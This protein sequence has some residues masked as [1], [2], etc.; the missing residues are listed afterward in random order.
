[1]KS[2]LPHSRPEW[3]TFVISCAVLAFMVVLIAT[4]AAGVTQPA[5]PVAERHGSVRQL[6]GRFVV[7]VRIT[8]LGDKTAQNVQVVAEL[9]VRDMVET[10]DQSIDFL[11][12]GESVAV[13]FIFD[14]D[15][16][17]ST[18]AGEATFRVGVS[19]FEEP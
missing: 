13:D 6:A 16:D 14:T 8:N 2:R 18:S 5:A 4:Q 11:S 17:A 15:P 3:V 1:M 9:Q 7:P 10:G 19:G 12:G